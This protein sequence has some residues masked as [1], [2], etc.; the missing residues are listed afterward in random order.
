MP[1]TGDRLLL[2]AFP[3]NF[4]ARERQLLNRYGA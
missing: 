2:G 4:T 3:D 1:A